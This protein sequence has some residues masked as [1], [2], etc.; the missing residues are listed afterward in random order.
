MPGSPQEALIQRMLGGAGGPPP[1]DMGGGDYGPPPIPPGPPE[2]L[3]EA[4][5]GNGA[6]LSKTE[7]I[8]SLVQ[9]IHEAMKIFP[10]PGHVA[11]LSKMLSVAT[12]LQKEL[13]SPSQGPPVGSQ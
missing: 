4:P 9:D 12:G 7:V 5:G 11:T 3:S 1:P 6:G 13:M 2:A 8:Q 10:D